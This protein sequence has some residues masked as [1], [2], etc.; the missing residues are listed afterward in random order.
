MLDYL[1]ACFH[2]ASII[3]GPADRQVKAIVSYASAV[4]L[5]LS[6]FYTLVFGLPEYYIYISFFALPFIILGILYIPE[7]SSIRALQ[8]NQKASKK[9]AFFLELSGLALMFLTIYVSLNN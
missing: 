8:N 5:W 2:K 6:S 3:Y 7:K 1:Y 9:L 4:A